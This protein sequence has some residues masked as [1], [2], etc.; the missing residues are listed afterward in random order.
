MFPPSIPG[1]LGVHPPGASSTDQRLAGRAQF[2]AAVCKFSLVLP[3]IGTADSPGPVQHRRRGF[4]RT[5]H[6]FF[7]KNDLATM[8]NEESRRR[9]VVRCPWSVVCQRE[10]GSAFTLLELLI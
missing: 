3:G 6:S 1:A 2:A 9:P 4:V 7:R 8:A 10:R 5:A